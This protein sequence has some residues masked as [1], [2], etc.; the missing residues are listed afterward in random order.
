[1]QS[2]SLRV[3]AVAART[4]AKGR[5]VAG[6]RLVD[7]GLAFVAESKEAIAWSGD[8]LDKRLADR[9][10]MLD[11]RLQDRDNVVKDHMQAT[12]CVKQLGA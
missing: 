2:V 5:G 10:D 6:H 12:W 3:S 8:L 4:G 9:D 1:V 11:R 7:A